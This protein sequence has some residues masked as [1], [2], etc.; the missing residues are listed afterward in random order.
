[1][2]AANV[3]PPPPPP[4]PDPKPSCLTRTA[5][6]KTAF[7]VRRGER[8]VRAQVRQRG[9]RAR[10]LTVRRGKVRVRS[11]QLPRTTFSLR[12][13]VRKGSKTRTVT[14]TWRTCPPRR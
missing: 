7:K 9:K 6:L 5:F 13:T 10:T 12:L 2:P 11:T 14:R 8:I 4:G 1:V 3:P